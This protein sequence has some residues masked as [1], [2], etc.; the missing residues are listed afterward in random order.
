M[1]LVSL[2]VILIFAIAS[3][4]YGA[5][6]V[7]LANASGSLQG[8]VTVAGSIGGV[9]LLGWLAVRLA[10]AGVMTFAEH[11]FRLG[12]AWRLTVGQFWRLLLTLGLT[13]LFAVLVVIMA[14]TLS[15]ILAKVTG[16]FTMMGQLAS[17]DL[18]HLTPALALGLLGELLLQ[19]ALQTLLI[20]LVF[21]IFYAPPAAA[22]R[23]LKAQPLD[24]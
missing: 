12:A 23:R 15:L 7:T 21:V 14:L 5:L 18:S 8:V 22:Y 17:P 2:L 9:A 19:L 4:V 24:V 16:G 1:F 3:G 6:V 10:L 13:I 20:V 11:H